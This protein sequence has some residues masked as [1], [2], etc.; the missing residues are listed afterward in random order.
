M[1]KIIILNGSPRKN[2]RTA[3][4]VKAFMEGAESSGNEIWEFHLQG[5]NI[6]GCL[7]INKTN[8]RLE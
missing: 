5:M 1:K 8:S 4:L 3:E 6:Q 2:G 7:G